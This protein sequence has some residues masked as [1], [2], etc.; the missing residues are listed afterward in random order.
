MPGA[1]E[2]LVLILLIFIFHMYVCFLGARWGGERGR[3]GEGFFLALFFSVFGLIAIAC[4]RPERDGNAEKQ[5]DATRAVERQLAAVLKELQEQGA[6]QN[7][8]AN[9][10]LATAKLLAILAKNVE[11]SEP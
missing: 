10:T 9:N 1:G 11:S 2:V 5:L 3:A 7:A 4:V 6:T 8:L